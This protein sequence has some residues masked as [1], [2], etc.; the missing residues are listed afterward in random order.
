MR[1]WDSKGF[2]KNFVENKYLIEIC[3]FSKQ[4]NLIL[5]LVNDE[6]ILWRNNSEFMTLH[7]NGSMKF[8][9]LN[10]NYCFK[11]LEENN[12]L[13][14]LTIGRKLCSRNSSFH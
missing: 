8:W 6:I 13:I 12:V 9:L 2:L 7:S 1:I 10:L 11:T 4:E 3:R 14:K 5:Y